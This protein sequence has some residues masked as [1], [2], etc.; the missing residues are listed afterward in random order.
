MAD[1][2]PSKPLFE[3]RAQKKYGTIGDHSLISVSA[4]VDED[5]EEA[6]KKSTDIFK[7]VLEAEKPDE[8]WTGTDKE[9]PVEKIIGA[10]L[11]PVA[12]AIGSAVGAGLGAAGG[13]A[14]GAVKTALGASKILS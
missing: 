7:R 12:G 4:S 13:I 14:G 11:A 6:L 3:P 5:E 8:T 2:T 1:D 9:V 10:L